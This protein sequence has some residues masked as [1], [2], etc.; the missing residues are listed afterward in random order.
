M[1]QTVIRNLPVKLPLLAL[2]VLTFFI[3]WTL[4]THTAAGINYSTGTY[5]SCTYGTCSISLATSGSISANIIPTA[6]QTKCTVS[7]DVVTA[8]TD[9]STGYTVTLADSDTANNLD[10]PT[11]IA[12]NT[13]TSSSPTTLV[14]NSWGYRVDAVDGFGAGP[15][16][17]VS[18]GAIPSLTFAGAPLST[19]TPALIRTTNTT[20][21]GTVNTS[22]WYGVCANS[23]LQSG[24]YTDSITYTA[25]I[26]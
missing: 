7:N 23:S 10:G 22:V 24:A 9:S 2:A 17:T 18:S 26:N 3:A 16:T 13:S 25:V 19:G 6:G 5:G 4:L 14:A 12:A 15:T 20:D 8:T 11:T 21:T 1:Q